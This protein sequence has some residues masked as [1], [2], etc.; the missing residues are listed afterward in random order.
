M[1]IAVAD[2]FLIVAVLKIARDDAVG[3]QRALKLG[4]ALALLAFLAAALQR[5]LQL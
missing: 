5:H 1:I 2:F 4:M 3:S